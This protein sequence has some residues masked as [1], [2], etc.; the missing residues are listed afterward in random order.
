MNKM[1]SSS[2]AILINSVTKC[3]LLGMSI[4]YML[5]ISKS[6][7]IWSILFGMIFNVIVFSMLLYIFNKDTDKT[8]VGKI[9]S[10][11]SKPIYYIFVHILIIVGILYGFIL[12]W[13]LNSFISNEFLSETPTIYILML[14][15]LPIFYLS[16]NSFQ[17]L[18]R[19]TLLSI[20][21]G[22]FILV[23]NFIGLI[24]HFELT[25]ISPISSIS[26]I[27]LIK[28][29]LYFTVTSITPCFMLTIIEKDNITD[30]EKFNK[31]MW[32]CLTISMILCLCVFLAI[33]LS[34]NINLLNKYTYPEFVV[35]KL[36]NIFN[37]LETLENISALL[38]FAYITIA[39]GLC[40]IF[41]KNLI[42]ELYN[43]KSVKTNKLIGIIITFLIFIMCIPLIN[44]SYYLDTLN[45]AIIPFYICLI[46]LIIFAILFLKYKFNKNK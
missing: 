6:A 45:I 10:K 23:F 3:F 31:T 20:L 28:S 19:F 38:W 26:F 39:I 29:S 18:S 1:K 15:I 36:I 16:I 30:K 35:L 24:P 44:Y 40:I 13:Q 4:P 7:T 34:L 5:K 32:G 22:L 14:I 11:F 17:V 37:F 42:S 33:Q 21:I 41:S 12:L 43:I 27:N 46:S 9:K 25:N 8:I 2:V